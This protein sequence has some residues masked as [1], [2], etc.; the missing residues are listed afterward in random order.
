MTIRKAAAR[1]RQRRFRVRRKT[2]AKTEPVARRVSGQTYTR[3]VTTRL[4]RG[5]AFRRNIE[6]NRRRPLNVRS[7]R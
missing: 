6:G 4:L 2:H 1:H 3:G 7:Y 5:T